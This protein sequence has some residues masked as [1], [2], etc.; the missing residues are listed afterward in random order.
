MYKINLYIYIIYI[1]Y[2]RREIYIRNFYVRCRCDCG[3]HSSPTDPR[4][5]TGKEEEKKKRET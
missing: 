2:Y 5:S 1:F 4:L 3:S